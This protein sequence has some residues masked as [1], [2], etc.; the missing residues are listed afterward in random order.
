MEHNGYDIFAELDHEMG[1]D[2]SQWRREAVASFEGCFSV[3]CD[4]EQSRSRTRL[5]FNNP[6]VREMLKNRTINLLLAELRDMDGSPKPGDLISVTGET[7]W[8][9]QE[10]GDD[11]PR[12]RKL[13]AGHKIQGDLMHYDIGPYIDEQGLDIDVH[14]YP[15][16]LTTQL[17][18]FGLQLVLTDLSHHDEF[19]EEL[20]M[21]AKQIYLPIHYQRAE[22]R[23][24]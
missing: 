18:M 8:H 13:P 21:T 24:Y 11:G 6:A 9:I 23:L 2:L 19:G 5:D 14:L 1:R 12:I 10:E 22:L 20:R 7:Y 16:R 4:I 17:K 3:A 15:E